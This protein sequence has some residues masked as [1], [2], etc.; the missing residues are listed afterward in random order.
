MARPGVGHG[1]CF[2]FTIITGGLFLLVWILL[3]LLADFRSWRC[4]Q[5]GA[6]YDARVDPWYVNRRERRRNLAGGI[7]RLF[8]VTFLAF[9]HA[10]A[11]A[12]LAVGRAIAALPGEV[13]KAYHGLPEWATPIVWGLG[14]AAPIVGGFLVW[15]WFV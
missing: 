6:I 7:G 1:W 2:L 10:V 4:Q 5:C 15:R 9:G 11:A 8:G 12:F 14:L 13:S 3:G